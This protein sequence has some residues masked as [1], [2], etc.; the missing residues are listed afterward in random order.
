MTDREVR[1]VLPP[2]IIEAVTAEVTRRVLDV[3][4]EQ[5]GQS[6]PWLTAAQVADRLG[7]P[8]KRVRNLTTAKRLPHH[9]VGRRVLYSATEI[10]EWM[11]SQ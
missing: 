11:R 9:R 3:L 4:A 6:S 7:W 8:L 10:D 2:E 1:I 5:A